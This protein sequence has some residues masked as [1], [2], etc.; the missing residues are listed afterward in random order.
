[1]MTLPPR[2][3][4]LG[5]GDPGREALLVPE[6]GASRDMVVERV[7]SAEALLTA[8]RTGRADVLVMGSVLH[9]LTDSMLDAVRQTAVPL[10]VLV[11]TSDAAR[12]P[13]IVLPPDATTAAIREA[14][15]SAIQ[16]NHRPLTLRDGRVAGQRAL[17]S[18][19][20]TALPPPLPVDGTSPC[21]VIAVAG[22]PGAPGRTTVTLNLATALGAVAPTVLVEVDLG[23]SGIVA[24]LNGDP[25][26]SLA[27]VAH[28]DPRTPTEMQRVVEREL[29]PIHSRSPYGQVL[30]GLQMWE[31]RGVI[32]PRVFEGV[33][34]ALRQRAR[35]VILDLGDDLT[36]SE[37]TLHRT[38]L[39]CAQQVLLVVRPDIVGL[40]RASHT[41]HSCR[42]ELGL[43]GEQLA[44]V[45]N[46]YTPRSHD[47]P[48]TIASSLG[49]PLAAVIP[50]DH[51]RMQRALTVQRPV[52]LTSRQGAAM[53]FLDLADRIHGGTI[54]LPP[55]REAKAG[56]WW[57]RFQGASVPVRR[58][59][60]QWIRRPASTNRQH[61]TQ[62]GRT[63]DEHVPVTR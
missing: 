60:W 34:D 3:V 4:V 25:T 46:A 50:A 35:Y 57:D 17:E 44:L 16:G 29:Q 30:L 38:A 9:R 6:L 41:V 49:L 56:G 36:S 55:E 31:Q 23:A 45:V 1:M 13:G 63:T 2:H 61:S 47:A 37:M 42:K 39:A 8:A 32:S 54:V 11:P 12:W 43:D 48:G 58:P 19:I 62:E 40:W 24:A 7:L 27:V 15:Q 18:D 20:P 53:A 52:V 26:R 28:A 21:S 5:L 14:I 10:V 59:V 22:P 51:R 33:L